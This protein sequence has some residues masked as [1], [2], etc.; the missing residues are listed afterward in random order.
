[1][2]LVSDLHEIWQVVVVG[3]AVVEEATFLDQQA[4]GVRRAGRPCVPAD[5]PGAGYRFYRP[6]GACDAVAFLGLIQIGVPFPAP[7]I[8]RHLGRLTE[9]DDDGHRPP[10]LRRA[11]ADRAESPRTRADREFWSLL[12]GFAA[13]DIPQSAPDGLSL[14][15]G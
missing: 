10:G 12:G 9:V 6:H 8:S 14:T 1:V 7:A 15:G 13:F 2:P 5:R 11:S 4:S 3:V